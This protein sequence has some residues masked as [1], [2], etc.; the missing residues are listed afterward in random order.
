MATAFPSVTFIWKYEKLQDEF[1]QGPA[2]AVDN[3]V[4][5]DWMPQND[6]LALLI[7]IFGDQPRNSAMIEH[8]KLGMV[9]GKLDI[10]NYAKI[11]A[12]LKE[13]ME[14]EEYAENSKRVSRMLAKKPFS[15]KEKLL[16]YVNFAAEFG[17]SSALRP[18]SVDMSFIEYL[19]IDI[20][21]V[22]FLVILGTLWLFIK[23]A[24]IVLRNIF[25]TAK[26][27]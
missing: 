27:E 18:Q 14:N 6:R 24:R 11:I 4:L 8:N 19:N 26:N 12:L 22:V 23:S 13:L 10:G 3:L 20:I 9:L 2:A 7:P 15:S 25:R 1:A 21:F 5:A 16:K 17:P